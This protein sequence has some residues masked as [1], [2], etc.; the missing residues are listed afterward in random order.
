MTDQKQ[1]ATDL[2]ARAIDVGRKVLALD[3][4]AP[5]H[6]EQRGI[7]IDALRLIDA[8]ARDAIE[9]H[10]AEALAE[11]ARHRAASE[12]GIDGATRAADELERARLAASGIDA[13]VFVERARASLAAGQP[14]RAALLLDV[15]ADKGLDA[16]DVRLATEAALDEADPKRRAAAEIERELDRDVE[17]L[18]VARL[19]VLAQTAGLAH[20]GSA[21]TGTVADR[22]H[23]SA[24]AKLARF[25][26]AR[27]RG[28]EYHAEPD[29]LAT[30]DP[31]VPSRYYDALDQ[32]RERGRR[33]KAA[34]AA[35]TPAVLS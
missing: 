16:R 35:Q 13:D 3:K 29:D 22:A 6:E 15:A 18:E 2:V 1:R 11:A 27:R 30:G 21:G 19:R 34:E 12:A 25:A 10:R 20:D 9:A 28:D 8:Q 32:A 5:D 14:R 17:D 24:V 26:V 31:G 23:A 4:T 33:Q 7:G